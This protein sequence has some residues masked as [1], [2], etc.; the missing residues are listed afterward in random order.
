MFKI[1]FYMQDASWIGVNLYPLPFLGMIY[2]NALVCSTT[3]F[4]FF[5]FFLSQVFSSTRHNTFFVHNIVS[6]ELNKIFFQ[7]YSFFRFF[8]KTY[9]FSWNG[10]KDRFQAYCEQAK[11]RKRERNVLIDKRNRFLGVFVIAVITMLH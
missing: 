7:G 11:Q 10:C 4:V 1:D 8:F 5:F 9:C 6:R 3:I 2:V